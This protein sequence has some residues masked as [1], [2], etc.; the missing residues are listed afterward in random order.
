M[1][2]F[3]LLR[4]YSSSFLHIVFIEHW[5]CALGLYTIF[6][7]WWFRFFPSIL[8]TLLSW[9]KGV[10]FFILFCSHFSVLSETCCYFA[11]FF[12]VLTS[13]Q[14]HC[15]AQTNR[16]SHRK[17]IQDWPYTV[18][19]SL[20]LSFLTI[21]FVNKMFHCNCFSYVFTLVKWMTKRIKHH[22]SLL[23]HRF[24]TA[25]FCSLALNFNDTPMAIL[26]VA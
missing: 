25:R 23:L 14:F 9:V 10:E 15:K 24:S 2:C 17:Y 18:S 21:Y 7:S 19:P 11:A 1:F 22:L 5:N 13:I 12:F 26:F 8:Y 3:V 20:S 16:Q 6:S 4:F